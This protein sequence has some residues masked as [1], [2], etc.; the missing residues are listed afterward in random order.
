SLF[1][2]RSV[3]KMTFDVYLKSWEEDQAIRF[4]F[5][6]PL[7]ARAY[8]NAIMDDWMRD[9]E[10]TCRQETAIDRL[11]ASSGTFMW[12]TCPYLGE[13][14]RDLLEIYSEKPMAENGKGSRKPPSTYFPIWRRSRRRSPGR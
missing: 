7:A 4:S 12:R 1:T 6:R 14:R 5:K 8:A 13:R 2:L 3:E 10:L 11:P 9:L